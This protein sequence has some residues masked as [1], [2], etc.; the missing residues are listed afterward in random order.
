MSS[1]I[2]WRW[3]KGHMI[4]MKLQQKLAQGTHP[5]YIQY[6]RC[7]RLHY[8]LNEMVASLT[9]ATLHFARTTSLSLFELYLT[10]F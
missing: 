10:D 3:H 2:S 7:I 8:F 4:S 9:R 5:T 1:K 6:I